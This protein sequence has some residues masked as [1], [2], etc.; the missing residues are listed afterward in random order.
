M[1]HLTILPT[2]CLLSLYKTQSCAL[3]FVEA[4]AGM[5][6]FNSGFQRTR[7]TGGQGQ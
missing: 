3:V 1:L 4:E 7:T 5:R 2:A 6:E